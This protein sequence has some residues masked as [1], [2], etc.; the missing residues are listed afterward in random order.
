MQ[1]GTTED[2][3][4]LYER[5]PYPSP[6]VGESLVRDVASLLRW[7]LRDSD[8]EGWEV[9]DA[10]CGTG[11]RLLGLASEY[12]RARFT[13]VDVSE[14]SLDIARRIAEK[15]GIAN[16]RFERADLMQL[17]LG[18]RF[19]LCVS[20]GV[21]HHLA[22]PEQGLAALQRHLAPG[23]VALLWMYHALGE[24]ERLLDRELLR[25]L[26]GPDA[27]DLARGEALLAALDLHVDAHR[28][29]D[30]NP[31]GDAACQASLDADAYL[32]PVVRAYR[33]DEAIALCARCGF[34]WVAVNGLNMQ[35]TQRL[36][37]GSERVRGVSRLVDLAG[38]EAKSLF[39][40][41]EHELFASDA[42]LERYRRLDLRGRL[43]VVE[44]RCRPTG[45]SLLCGRGDSHAQ[46]GERIR[47]NL[48]PL[49]SDTGGT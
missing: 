16:T 26:L 23:G 4:A 34:D 2:V 17:A 31:S 21:I 44:L 8:L 7:L 32:N 22:S 33:F 37:D 46:F 40:L 30:S 25:G 11:Q 1:H 19:D 13:G 42:L 28:Y 49:P 9:L 38:V 6:A 12:P 27:G 39:A 36:P 47:G 48:I 35:A 24:A 18:R 45:F 10:G 5:F 41:K 15:H 43:R 3:Q 29:G 14:A 20:T